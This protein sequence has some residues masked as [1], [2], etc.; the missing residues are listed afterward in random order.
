MYTAEILCLGNELL[1]GVTINTNAAYLGEK[2]T[3]LGFEV[4]RSTSVRD[5]LELASQCLKEILER[6][7]NVLIITGGLGPTYDDIQM[8]VVSKALSL[9]LVESSKALKLIEE[10]YA[11]IGL[12]LTPERRK[13]AN[14]PKGSD[15][16]NNTVGSAPGCKITYNETEI[17]CLPGVPTEMKDIFERNIYPYLSDKYKIA[18]YEKQFIVMNCR[19]SELAPFINKVKKLNP[20]VYIKSHPQFV[21]REGITIHIACSGEKCENRVN[22][23]KDELIRLFTTNLN[24]IRIKEIEV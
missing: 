22:Q 8:E 20:S 11:V 10:S 23:I 12:K 18:R 9:P 14:L 16:L 3:F 6:H 17:F 2:L 15:I 21:G 7:P 13:M 19:E 5:D 1:M 4:R 24:K